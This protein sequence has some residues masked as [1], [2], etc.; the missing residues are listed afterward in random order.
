LTIEK[1]VE[2][3]GWGLGRVTSRLIVHTNL[4]TKKQVG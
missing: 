4:Q 3:P 2:T 1:H